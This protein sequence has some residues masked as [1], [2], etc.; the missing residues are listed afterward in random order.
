MITK[1]KITAKAISYQLIGYG[2]LMFLITGD[3]IFDFPHFIFGA[4]AT[5]INWTETI[6]EGTY[7]VLLCAFTVYL[8]LRFLKQIKFLEGFLP[9]C[10]YCKKI[11]KENEW[12][13]L[14]KYMSDHSEALFSHG[15]CPDCADKYYGE[16]LH[17][18]KDNPPDKSTKDQA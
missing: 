4:P 3:E 5:P 9:I 17:Q 16:F 2:I 14:E 6:V 8:S 12:T 7:I 13:S 11:R 18:E 1:N 10:S 15:L